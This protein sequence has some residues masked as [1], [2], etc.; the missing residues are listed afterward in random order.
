MTLAYVPVALL[1]GVL[2]AMVVAFL[3]RVRP[4][5]VPGAVS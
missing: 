3:R 4:S 2:T 5:M 1:E